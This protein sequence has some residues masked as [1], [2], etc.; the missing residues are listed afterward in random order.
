MTGLLCKRYCSYL[1]SRS[2][3]G[4][5]SYLP[6]QSAMSTVPRATMMAIAHGRA[7]AR[8]FNGRVKLTERRADRHDC[9]NKPLLGDAIAIANGRV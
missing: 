6:R 1:T 3:H 8:P 9:W 4:K 7:S 2:Q 5:H